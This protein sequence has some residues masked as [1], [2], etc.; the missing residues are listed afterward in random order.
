M[1]GAS[2][3]VSRMLILQQSLI[4]KLENKDF[5]NKAP[6]HVI[7]DFQRQLEEIKSSIEKID[8]IINTIN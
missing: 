8:Q 6:K 5:I 1:P 3:F 7:E 2:N 4:V